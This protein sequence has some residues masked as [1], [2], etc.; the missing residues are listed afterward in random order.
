MRRRSRR[1]GRGRVRRCM[2]MRKRRESKGSSNA[3]THFS[4][5]W[6]GTSSRP[7]PCRWG[8]VNIPERLIFLL[9]HSEERPKHRMLTTDCWQKSI[10]ISFRKSM[11]SN[12]QS[13]NIIFLFFFS[14][15]FNER[16]GVPSP[17]DRILH[18]STSS[19]SSYD[20]NRRQEAPPAVSP[21]P[22]ADHPT[23]VWDPPW[24]GQGVHYTSVSPPLWCG[25]AFPT[26]SQSEPTEAVVSHCHQMPIRSGFKWGFMASGKGP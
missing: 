1:R 22:L 13:F 6:S 14:L 12:N 4:Q 2:R 8:E 20:N 7:P 26:V 18:G 5:E 25:S 15:F 19:S 21:G 9:Q 17:E 16:E 24:D 3:P 23:Q 10:S 11:K